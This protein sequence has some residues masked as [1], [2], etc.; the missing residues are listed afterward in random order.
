VDTEVKH[1]INAEE[2]DVEPLSSEYTPEST[3]SQNSF[4][5]S[6]SPA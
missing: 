1:P 5:F 3:S 2:K 4:F 6:R